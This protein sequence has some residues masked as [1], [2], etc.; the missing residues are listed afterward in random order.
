M[1][2]VLEALDVDF[3][4]VFSAG[5][6]AANILQTGFEQRIG[7]GLDPAGDAGVGVN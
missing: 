6:R 2:L 4:D 5:G 3:V 7:A 1:G